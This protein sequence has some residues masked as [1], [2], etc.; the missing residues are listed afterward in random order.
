[1]LPASTSSDYKNRTAVDNQTVR[2][3]F[4]ISPDK[5][6]KLILSYPMSTGRNFDEIVR[7]IDSLKLTAT[8]KVATP[9]NWKRGDNVIIVPAVKDDE[10]KK[11]FP[12]GW[13]TVKPYIREVKHQDIEK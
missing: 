7:V 2:N 12:D 10:A 9:A 1:M 6:I 8:H 13:K 4:I 11:L 5:K 3:V